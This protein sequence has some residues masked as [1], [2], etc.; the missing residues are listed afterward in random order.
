MFYIHGWEQGLTFPHVEII[1]QSYGIR[2]GWNIILLDY[3]RYAFGNYITVWYNGLQVGDRHSGA[4]R[5]QMISNFI[6]F[7]QLSKLLG[8]ILL[9]AFNQR[10]FNIRKFHVVGHSLGA[11]IAS[12]IGQKIIEGGKRLRRYFIVQ[13][14]LWH[15]LTATHLFRITGLDPAGPLNY[16]S[17]TFIGASHLSHKDAAFVDV[18]HTDAYVYGTALR[19]GKA[20]FYPN[21]GIRVQPGCPENTTPG[22]LSDIN[23]KRM[24][25]LY[26]SFMK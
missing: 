15:F 25:L 3:D 16:I 4:A 8:P 23:G 9:D 11:H 17:N 10:I 24:L 21:G 19:S 2:G 26:N 14:M 20:D 5:Q 7:L 22:N 13:F 1:P 6:Y 12:N 18:I